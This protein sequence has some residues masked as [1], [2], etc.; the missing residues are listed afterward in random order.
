[1]VTRI[2]QALTVFSVVFFPSIVSET[3]SFRT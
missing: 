3:P 2:A 1:L